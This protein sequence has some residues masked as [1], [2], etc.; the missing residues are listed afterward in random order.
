[1]LFV[2]LHSALKTI[3]RKLMRSSPR[4]CS[5]QAR[6]RQ[7]KLTELVP[8]LVLIPIRLILVRLI[9]V[10]KRVVPAP[11]LNLALDVVL[12]ECAAR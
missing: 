10:R 1:M 12:Q 11:K 7:E 8:R 9:L 4:A 2:W 6:P 5:R 3:Y